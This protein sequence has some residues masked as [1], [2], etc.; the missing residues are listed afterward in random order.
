M[1]VTNETIKNIFDEIS[2]TKQGMMDISEF[3]FALQQFIPEVSFDVAKALFKFEDNDSDHFIT[4][5]EFTNL[6][7]FAT[8]YP[9]DED[10]FSVL[11][12]KCQKNGFVTL[13]NVLKIINAINNSISTETITQFFLESDGN[14]DGLLNITEYMNCIKK[15]RFE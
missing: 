10:E 11:F 2:E 3:Y 14:K 5:K 8:Q 13:E 6:I 15:I 7:L 12:M 4:L 1:N 9:Q